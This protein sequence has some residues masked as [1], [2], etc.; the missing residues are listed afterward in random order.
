MTRWID[1]LTSGQRFLLGMGIGT[2]LAGV[3][4]LLCRLFGG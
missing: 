4:K 1:G 3:F 2:V